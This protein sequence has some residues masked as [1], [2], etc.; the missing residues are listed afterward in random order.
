MRRIRFEVVLVGLVL[1]IHL[2]AALTPADSL[3]RWFPSDDGFYYFKTA[4][5]ITEG[6]GISFDGLGRDSGFHPLWMA[7]ITPLFALARL[8][9]ILPLRLLVL[10]AGVLNAGTAVLLYRLTKRVI[11]PQAAALVG[12]FW[13]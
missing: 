4:Q 3:M 2:Y 11:P 5:N 13:A 8:D 10:L 7:L 9:L 12:L 6:H 1:L